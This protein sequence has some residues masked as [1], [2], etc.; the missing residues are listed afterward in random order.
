MAHA[1]TGEGS[2]YISTLDRKIVAAAKKKADAAAKK[3]AAAKKA[4]KVLET[5][6]SRR[7]R[8]NL[9]RPVPKSSEKSVWE[10]LSETPL[11]SKGGLVGFKGTF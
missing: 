1:K 9:G 6:R 2:K 11:F 5:D 7:S 3:K 4:A 10:E 8:M